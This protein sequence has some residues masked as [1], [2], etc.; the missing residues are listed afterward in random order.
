LVRSRGPKRRKKKWETR[1][2]CAREGEEKNRSSVPELGL[3]DRKEGETQNTGCGKRKHALVIDPR[4][5]KRF[6]P[7]P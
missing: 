5:K 2:V 7:E 6:F 3:K 4:K 1:A